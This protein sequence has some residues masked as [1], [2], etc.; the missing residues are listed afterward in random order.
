MNGNIV[1]ALKK[2]DELASDWLLFYSDKR[3]QFYIDKMDLLNSSNAPKSGGRSGIS[4]PTEQRIVRMSGLLKDEAWLELLE[5]VEDSLSER[6]KIFLSVRREAAYMEG[7]N[8]RGRPAWVV[9]VQRR[10]AEEM[11]LVYGGKPEKYWVA[12][13]T[14]KEWWN[15][16]IVLAA[17][18]AA[19]KGCL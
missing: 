10:Y 3:R 14:I 12:E 9:Y 1:A 17:R 4:K 13:T 11:A 15:K 5:V 19:K 18:A 7:N 8:E 16:L 2:D 6:K